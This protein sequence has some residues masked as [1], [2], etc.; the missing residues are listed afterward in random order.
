MKIQKGYRLVHLGGEPYLL[1][2]GQAAAN[3]Q[4][5]VRL[6]ETGVFLWNGLL[7]GAGEE[8]L[9]ERMIARYEP[10]EEELGMLRQDLRDFLN[11]LSTCR[12]L[13]PGRD[14][15]VP[16]EHNIVRKVFIGGIAAE[17]RGPEEFL[18]PELHPFCEREFSEEQSDRVP[19]KGTFI[20]RDGEEPRKIDLFLTVVRSLP[21][22]PAVG[23]ILARNADLMLIENEQEYI[24]LYSQKNGLAEWHLT[25][26]CR[27]ATMYCVM[28]F[29][30]GMAQEILH[31]FRM[32]YLILAQERGLFALHS[33]SV[34]YG[35]R[36]WLFSGHSGVGKSTHADLWR[37]LFGTPILNGD[38]NL[39]EVGENGE[40]TVYGIPWCGTSGISTRE[41]VLLGGVVFLGR[42]SKEEVWELPVSEGEL[43]LVQ[44]LVSPA[45]TEHMFLKNLEFA[46]TLASAVPL[47]GLR[48]TKE[49]SAA[50]TMRDAIDRVAASS[51]DSRYNKANYK[52]LMPD[53]RSAKE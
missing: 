6:N 7:E 27:E 37:D 44:R 42:G 13:T 25:K 36:A 24:C 48:C 33:A 1:P 3:L 26:N 29:G 38:L 21:S 19:G 35:G 34:L 8:E 2:Y 4:R 20:E 9:L 46:K 51:S 45:W 49:A 52:L 40:V 43:S 32:I 31:G 53:E 28:P 47:L 11:K 17:Y 18:P 16:F 39:L 23:E 10:M 5:G 41:N 30:D 22:F 15:A 14:G 50:V 12:I